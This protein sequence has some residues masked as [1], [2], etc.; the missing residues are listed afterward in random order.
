MSAACCGVSAD[1][2]AHGHDA[3]L[4][5]RL[6]NG[7]DRGFDSVVRQRF[8]DANGAFMRTVSFSDLSDP[9]LINHRRMLAI[10]FPYASD[11]EGWEFICRA[12]GQYLICGVFRNR[13]N[14]ADSHIENLEHF[15]FRNV[16]Q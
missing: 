3:A 5:K 14:Q 7:N 13:H 6:P 15:I 4:R 2:I 9:L 10:C 1:L 12:G 16:A 11:P 8:G